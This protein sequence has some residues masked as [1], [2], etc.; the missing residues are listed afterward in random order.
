[1]YCKGDVSVL[2]RSYTDIHQTYLLN[3]NGS[4]SKR[5]YL[6]LGVV[7]L[8]ERSYPRDSCPRGSRLRSVCC[9]ANSPNRPQYCRLSI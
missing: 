8:R 1:M 7:F 2:E 5:G 9:N 4:L 6:S 3:F